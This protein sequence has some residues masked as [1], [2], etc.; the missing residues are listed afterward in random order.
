MPLLLVL[1]VAAFPALA[2][3]GLRR[4]GQRA[5]LL[6]WEAVG[7]LD[8]ADGGF[9]TGVLVAPDLVL[10]AAHCLFDRQARRVDPGA[11]T[12]RA[13]F[14][15]GAAIAEVAGRRAVIHADY[16]PGA[17]DALARLSADA[18]LVQLAEPIPAGVAAPFVPGRAV[19]KGGAV[20][21]V[22]YATGRQDVLSWQPGCTVLDRRPGVYAFSCDVWFGSSGAPVFESSSGRARIVSIVSSGT[23]EDGRTIAYGMEAGRAL[24]DLMAAMRSGRGVFPEEA[25]T[26]RRLPA[27]GGRSDIGARF[28][29]P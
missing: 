11:L 28:V 7:R 27:A 9:C 20:S 15:Q 13:G 22:S 18:A 25:V 24:D 29:R 17:G 3:T 23:R 4:L 12:F 5:D 1:L 26:A 8:R 21:V 14:R 16:R 19:P 10:T 6:G 2:D